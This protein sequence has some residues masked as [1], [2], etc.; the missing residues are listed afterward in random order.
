[1]SEDH[2]QRDGWMDGWM[3]E[4]WK[5]HNVSHKHTMERAWREGYGQLVKTFGYVANQIKMVTFVTKTALCSHIL[6]YW[7]THNFA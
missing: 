2:G 4:R 6:C 3:G 5:K 7:G 1:M